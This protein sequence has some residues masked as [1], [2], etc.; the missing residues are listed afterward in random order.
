MKR[1]KDTGL[2][3][4][5]IPVFTD[6]ECPLDEIRFYTAIKDKWELIESRKF[7]PTR[8]QMIKRWFK[9]TRKGR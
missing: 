3:Y 6:E 4:N 5:G 2:Q 7:K 9:H 1:W 8:W